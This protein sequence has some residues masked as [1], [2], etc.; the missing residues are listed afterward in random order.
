MKRNRIAEIVAAEADDVTE[1]ENR[2]FAIAEAKK[3]AL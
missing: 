3:D 1:L 2:A